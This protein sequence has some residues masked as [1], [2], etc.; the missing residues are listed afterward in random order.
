MFR[1]CNI[2]A[3]YLV[4]TKG[5]TGVPKTENT[6]RSLWGQLEAAKARGGTAAFVDGDLYLPT[7]I[8]GNKVLR[9][10]GNEFFLVD[11]SELLSSSDGL[12]YRNSPDIQDK[13]P[14]T[15]KWGSRVPGEIRGDW[16]VVQESALFR[17]KEA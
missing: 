8:R 6:G 12:G 15:A 4:W 2:P 9:A 14:R 17:N 10:V 1:K 11:N 16:L 5:S 13:S 7:H 3:E